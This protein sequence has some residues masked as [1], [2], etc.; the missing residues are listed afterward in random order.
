[1]ARTIVADGATTSAGETRGYVISWFYP[2]AAVQSE[3]QDCPHGMNAKDAATNVLNILRGSGFDPAEIEKAMDDFPIN[4]YTVLATRA[5]IN[6]KPADPYLNPTAMP[7]LHLKTVEGA[8]A[9]GFNL[10][11]NDATGGFIDPDT[12]EKG[13]DNQ[14]FRVYGC[15]GALR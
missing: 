13:V 10:D 14:L 7:D 9:L 6:G 15:S 11:G 4:T 3:E 12:H 2:S 8:Y 1:V 5:R